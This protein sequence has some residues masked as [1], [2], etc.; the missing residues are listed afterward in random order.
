MKKS[1]TLLLLI[2]T[3]VCNAQNHKLWYEKP[4]DNWLEALPVGNSKLG[5]MVYGKTSCEEIQL[6]EETFWA[7]SPH[8]NVADSAWCYLDEVR[9]LIFD[10]EEQQAHQILEKNFFKGPHGMS[11]LP[12]GSVFIDFGDSSKPTNYRR[13]LDLSTAVNKTVY[14]IGDVS[15]TRT[16]VAPLSEKV[17][18]VNIKCSRKKSLGFKLSFSS[19]L[20]Y[21]SVVNN[22]V[23]NAQVL[24]TAQEGIEGKLKAECRVWTQTDG[25]I[26]DIDDH[27]EIKNATSATIY[28]T[29]ATNFKNYSD[30]TADAKKI[31]DDIVN[32]I[33]PK[34]YKSIYDS[35]IKLY[36]QQYNRVGLFLPSNSNSSLPTDVRLSN[37]IKSNDYD[38]VSLM[39]QYG[40]YLLISSSQP[41]GQPANLQGIWNSQVN[42]P[43]DS[44]YTININTEMNYWPSGVCNLSETELPLFDMLADLS[45]T[46]VDAAKKLYNCGGWTAHHNT[47]LW[48]ISGPVDGVYWGMFPTGGAWLST[49]IWQ[50]Y[51][52]SGDVDF[53]RKNYGIMEGAAVFLLDFLTKH[54]KYGCLVITPSVS[55]EHGP[56]G[57]TT[58]LTAGTT[59]DNQIV[60]D[61]LSNTLEAMKILKI[62]N[63]DLSKR[64]KSALTNLSAMK[65]GRHGQLQEWLGDFDNP[66]DEHRHVSHLYGLYPSNQISPYRNPELFW[67]ARNTL[68]QRGD[69]ATG[70]SLGWKINFWAR[71]LDGNHAFK[72]ISNMLNILPSRYSGFGVDSKYSNG[73]IYPNLF[74]AHPPFQIDGNFGLTAG[75]CEMLLQSHDGAV[76]LLPALPDVWQKGSVFGLCARG[77]FTVGMTWDNGKL[78]SA[79][80]V[81]NNGGVLRLRSYSQ[82]KCKGL[83]P[84]EGVCS[85]HFLTI[86]NIKKPEISSE[87]DIKP[88]L[89]LKKV[90][91]YD[92]ETQK[93]CKYKI[94]AVD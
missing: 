23:I 33:K 57:K 82:L 4:A 74:D 59:M 62:T 45:V 88:E 65:I 43:W 20:K 2:L 52:F 18:A 61:V 30:I 14:E 78:L 80:I 83:K 39:V 91:E 12:L 13:E 22:G 92:L 3:V 63:L 87:L 94:L 7:G 44:K 29:A 55:P 53:L 38:F 46:G 35:H 17:V 27:L 75:V 40:R 6:N 93:G 21:N 1:I 67:A 71:M 49:H 85:N 37:F 76:H 24:N 64:L 11:F 28:I 19:P 81:S 42:P 56:D 50:H 54:P 77:G 79:E 86:A 5:A 68:L 70:W 10:A 8:N 89:Q 31:V 66:T 69:M 47:D 41:G 9:N 32:S 34:S 51:L 58:S 15:Y 60:F 84:A 73:R 26:S 90:Y 48:R 72:I 25:E 36:S 16:V